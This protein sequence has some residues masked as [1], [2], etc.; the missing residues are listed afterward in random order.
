MAQVVKS[1]LALSSIP[2]TT[3]TGK[4]KKKKGK[5]N[6]NV[7]QQANGHSIECRTN[8]NCMVE[9]ANIMLGEDRPQRVTITLILCRQTG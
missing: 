4:R 1:L 6:P 8:C 7:H 5:Y 9:P 3:T 2:S